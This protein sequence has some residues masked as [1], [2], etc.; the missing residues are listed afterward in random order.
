MPHGHPDADDSARGLELGTCTSFRF[1]TK[2]G[3]NLQKSLRSVRIFDTWYRFTGGSQ[4]TAVHNNE[5]MSSFFSLLLLLILFIIISVRLPAGRRQ[6]FIIA[7]HGEG[8]QMGHV[9]EQS[10]GFQKIIC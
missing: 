9:A 4:E 6:A 1:E 7:H 10:R 8:S 3:G 2:S 5:R